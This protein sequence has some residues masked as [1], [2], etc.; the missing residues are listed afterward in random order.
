MYYNDVY[1]RASTL[2]G[3]GLVL[4]VQF[5]KNEVLKTILLAGLGGASSY[6]FSQVVMLIIFFIK[7]RWLSKK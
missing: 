1:Q 4:L 3:V 6:A 5:E 7:N 2:F